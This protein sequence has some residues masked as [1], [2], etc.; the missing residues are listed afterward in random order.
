[1]RATLPPHPNFFFFF[2]FGMEGGWDEVK[3]G[4]VYLKCL[5]GKDQGR[6]DNGL[7]F[8]CPR[9][10]PNG[11]FQANMHQIL[12]TDPF[13]NKSHVVV[14][15]ILGRRVHEMYTEVRGLHIRTS[16]VACRTVWG[17]SQGSNTWLLSFDQNRCIIS[18]MIMIPIIKGTEGSERKLNVRLV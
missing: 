3:G 17:P 10:V 1:M 7:C 8:S 6:E 16:T 2:C 9:R 5:W 14:G 13:Q 11:K 15:G 18:C 12:N 4:R